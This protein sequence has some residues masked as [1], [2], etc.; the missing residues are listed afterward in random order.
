VDDAHLDT[1]P[2]LPGVL[3]N[4]D[5]SIQAAQFFINIIDIFNPPKPI[6]LRKWNPREL[7]KLEA[8]K[9]K[10]KMLSEEICPFQFKHLL[11]CI[12]DLKHIDRWGVILYDA[13]EHSILYICQ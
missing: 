3:N 8:V 6:F 1:E 9:L 4:L 11:K 5:A 10:T 13:G 2:L 12:I 7:K